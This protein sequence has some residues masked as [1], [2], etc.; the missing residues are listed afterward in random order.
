MAGVR[1]ANK[2]LADE[3]EQTIHPLDLAADERILRRCGLNSSG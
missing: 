1:N 2:I 3:S